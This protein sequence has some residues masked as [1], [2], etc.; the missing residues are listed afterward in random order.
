MAARRRDARRFWPSPS[1]VISVTRDQELW[2]VALWV[3]KAHGEQGRDHIAREISRVAMLGEEEGI[4]MW[5]AVAA[6]YVKLREPGA[7]N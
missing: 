3:E 4:A 1:V 6:R 2:A 7:V 5:E